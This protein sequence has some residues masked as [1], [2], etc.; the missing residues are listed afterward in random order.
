MVLGFFYCGD[1]L[2]FLRGGELIFEPCAFLFI[3]FLSA[4]DYPCDEFW[5]GRPRACFVRLLAAV[6]MLSPSRTSGATLTPVCKAFS[7]ITL[8]P[9][10]R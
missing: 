6:L 9:C 1:A 8:V 2:A 10:C 7:P 4:P 5:A 3:V